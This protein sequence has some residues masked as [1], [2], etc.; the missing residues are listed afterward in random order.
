MDQVTQADESSTTTTWQHPSCGIVGCKR[1]S[2][3]NVSILLYPTAPVVAAPTFTARG[4]SVTVGCVCKKHRSAWTVAS[5]LD[6]PV[7]KC[8]KNADLFYKDFGGEPDPA[9][10]RIDVVRA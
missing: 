5:F 2:S 4:A 10:A 8:S 9:L 3:F 6:S 1:G 7:W